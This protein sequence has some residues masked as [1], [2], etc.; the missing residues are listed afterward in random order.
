[1][2]VF[3]EVCLCV[4][5]RMTVKWSEFV[6]ENID[7]CVKEKKKERENV[8]KECVCVRATV[9]DRERERV[10]CFSD[11]MLCPRKKAQTHHFTQSRSRRDIT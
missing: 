10:N 5:K 8:W 11:D 3:E 7:V 6:R 1:M 4:R 2:S 9:R